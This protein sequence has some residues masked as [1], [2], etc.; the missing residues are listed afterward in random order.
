MAD[1]TLYYSTNRDFEGFKDTVSFREALFM[2]IAPDEGLFMPDNIP[3]ISP[4]EIKALKGKPYSDVAYAV[5][6]R[7]L[8]GDIDED[9]L[10]AITKEAYDFGIPIEQEGRMFIMRLDQGP[11]LSFKDFAARFMA[12]VM[13]ELKPKDEMLN[14]IVATSGDTGSA[15]G[16][17]FKGVEGIRVY[18]LYPKNEVSSVQKSQLDSI[19]MNVTAIS[20][21][22]KFDDCQKLA[23]QALADS[24]L[25]CLNLTSANSI[26]I[27]RVLPQIAYYFYAYANTANGFEPAVFSVPSGNFGNSLGCEIARRMGLPVEKLIIATNSN[28]EFPVF[29]STGLYKKIEPSHACISNAMNVGNPSNLARYFELYGGNLTKEGIVRRMPDIGEMKKQIYSVS[30]SDD[31]T[32]SIIKEYGKKGI[33][34]EP[35]GAVGVAALKKYLKTNKAGLC[36]C[37]ETAHPAKFPGIVKEA[38]GKEMDIPEQLRAMEKRKSRCTEMQNSY[39]E[40][41]KILLQEKEW[42]RVFAPATIGNIGPG[43]DVLGMAVK[44]IGDVVEARKTEEGVK[45]TEITDEYGASVKL[46]ADAEKNTAGIAA[47]ET[48]KMLGIK[49]GVELRI[50]KGLPIGSGLGSSAASASA[51]AFAVNCLYGNRLGKDELIMPATKAEEK[52][53]GA[54]FADNTAPA[55]LGGACLIRTYTPLDVTSIGSIGKLKIVL[56][57]PELEVLTR[58]AREILPEKVLMQD[59]VAN[60]ANSCMISIAFAKDDYGLFSRSLNDRIIEPARAVLI[61]GFDAAKK[62]AI[63][64]GADGMAISGSGPAVFAVTDDIEKAEKIEKAMLDAF[65]K[66]GVSARSIITEMDSEGARAL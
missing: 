23:K 44:G 22:G 54:F 9:K 47:I 60:M 20:I 53:S 50:R 12:R 55:L 59:F 21:S 26:N 24:E 45:I 37:I 51:A 2:G 10:R 7:F 5:L 29:L 15:V 56:V 61:K 19:G 3:V 6:S 39:D 4:E 28:D 36:I 14:I 40:L 34:L 49:G 62:A 32:I 8:A 35:H 27:A 41:K 13:R 48:L 52:V 30:I 25:R 38:T 33:A 31:E 58:D 16:E 46:S 65:K 42:I 11:T 57:T 1:K 43:F 18:I 17:A 63:D 64:A 66:Q